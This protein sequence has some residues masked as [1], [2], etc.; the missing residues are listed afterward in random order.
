MGFG[1]DGPREKFP[2]SRSTWGTKQQRPGASEKG[3]VNDT[4]EF[5]IPDR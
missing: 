4:V 5:D 2:V 3:D 1:A